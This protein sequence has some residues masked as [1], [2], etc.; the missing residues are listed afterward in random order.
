MMG[1]VW[2]LRKRLKSLECLPSFQLRQ[3][4]SWGSHAPGKEGTEVKAADGFC[5]HFT[6]LN[7]QDESPG[8]NNK[9]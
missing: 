2:E 3:L 6:Y 5:C 7:T 4:E 8:R 9:S 1:W